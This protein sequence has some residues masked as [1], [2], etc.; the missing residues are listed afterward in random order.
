MTRCLIW[1]S[2]APSEPR[3]SARLKSGGGNHCVK[4]LTKNDG[5]ECLLERGTKA[6][7]GTMTCLLQ[8][9]NSSRL[10]TRV[11]QRRSGNGTS[12]LLSRL[13]VASSPIR[14]P[15]INN[16]LYERGT[17]TEHAGNATGHPK[18][19]SKRCYRARG[20]FDHAMLWSILSSRAFV[21]R[22]SCENA[23]RAC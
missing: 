1:Q 17:G 19:L 8:T 14:L 15:N 4:L 12:F 22:S 16:C 6:K 11:P 9:S 23:V 5:D 20:V 13:F 21:R 2:A 7:G 3:R 18:L 10:T